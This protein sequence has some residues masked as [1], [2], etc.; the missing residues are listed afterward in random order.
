MK[1]KNF[2][3][4]TKQI[5]QH[6]PDYLEKHGFDTSRNFSCI[7][8]K[9][10]DSSPSMSVVRPEGIRFYCHGCAATGDIFDAC[11]HIEGKPL[12]GPGFMS[13]TLEYLAE[14]FGIEI[15][16]TELSEEEIYELDTYRAYRYAFEQLT[17]WTEVTEEVK[18]EFDKRNWDESTYEQLRELGVGYITDHTEFREALKSRGFAARFLDDVDL[19]RKDIFSP[20]HLIYT[21]KDEYGRPVGF[22]ARNLTDDGPKFVNQRTTGVRCNIYR[23]GQRLYGLDQAL[24]ERFEGPL[25]IMEGYADVITAQLK[26]FKR[27]VATCGTAL[28]NDHL[29]LLKE[30][31]IYNVVLCYDGDEAGQTRTENLLDSRFAEHK[32]VNVKVVVLPEG[33]DPDEYIRDNGIE[34]FAS[35]NPWT[36]FQWRLQ[37]FEEDADGEE[38]CKK[39]IPLIVSEPSHISQEKMLQDLARFTGFNLKTLQNEL[40]RLINDKDMAKDRERKTVIDKAINQLQRHPD[41]ATTIVNEISAKLYSLDSKYDQDNFSEESTLR[42]IQDLKAQEEEKTGDRQGFYLGEDLHELQ[43]IVLAGDCTRDVWCVFGGKAN[44]G[45]TSLMCKTAHAIASHEENN[46][47]VIYHTIDDTREQILPKFVCISEGSARLTINEVKNPVYV[48]KHEGEAVYEDVKLRRETGYSELIDLTRNGRL[49]IKDANDGSSLAYAESLIKYYQEKY[50]DR[51]VVYILDNF[52]KLRDFETAGGDERSRF[53]TMSTV[54]KNI[55]TK[56]HIPIFSTMEYTKLPRGTRPSNDNIA[57]TVQMEYD[58]NL[59]CHLYNE[60]HEL[61]DR[62][63]EHTYHMVNDR[64][65]QVRR[66]VIELIVGKNKISSFKSSIYFKF[67][68]AKSEFRPHPLDIALE[69]RERATASQQNS[70]PSRGGMFSARPN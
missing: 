23:K 45:K 21:I 34:A 70:G 38:M 56:Y 55:A 64:D 26:G 68:P 53:K 33:N 7:N 16:H 37:R 8:P 54:V 65:R 29:F 44:T 62:A 10:G 63:E 52:H 2:D 25:Y 58:A 13:E 67:H 32:D 42:F 20:G 24:R 1:V 6:L 49:I 35:L 43:D 61:G 59:I 69:E 46:A 30:H 19:G 15:E 22:A 36:A 12:T 27:A 9:H 31:S 18:A 41:Q 28:T 50:P 51:Q 4:V 40:H 17:S 66:P 14:E 5:Q 47:C 60:M 39:M 3:E 57:E 11:H 48:Q